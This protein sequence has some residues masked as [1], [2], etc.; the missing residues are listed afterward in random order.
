MVGGQ[1][2]LFEVIH[3]LEAK[4]HFPYSLDRWDHQCNK[5]RNDGD[6]YQE[7]D[8][9]QPLRPLGKQH[10]IFQLSQS[11]DFPTACFL[12]PCAY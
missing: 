12:T 1:S 9:S 5:Y 3:A 4:G 8:E 7:F 2:E 11:L 10:L 6:H